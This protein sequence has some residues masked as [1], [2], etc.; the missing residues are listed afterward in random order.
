VAFIPLVD[1]GG[2]GVKT[3]WMK[4]PNLAWLN[5]AGWS[6]CRAGTPMWAGRAGMAGLG[7]R[8]RRARD[9]RS[10]LGAERA[11]E[12]RR[13]GGEPADLRGSGVGRGPCVKTTIP[14]NQR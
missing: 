14:Q 10:G 3:Q 2:D 9:G 8:R 5:Q 11:R 4:M 13:G 7:G 6:S 1:A 12:E